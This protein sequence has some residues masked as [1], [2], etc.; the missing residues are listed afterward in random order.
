MGCRFCAT[1]S[2]KNRV[3]PWLLL[4]WFYCKYTIALM[5]AN[6]TYRFHRDHRLLTGDRSPLFLWCRIDERCVS[7]S[8]CERLYL[9]EVPSLERLRRCVLL[10]GCIRDHPT[11]DWRSC[12]L[13]LAVVQ[14]CILQSG[15]ARLRFLS[16]G[17][18]TQ[19]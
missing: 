4:V 10:I 11:R 19:V 16:V 7:D 8:A 13:A 2:P 18:L 5:M 6:Q 9:L 3:Y 1:C 17:Q 15:V 12:P 14:G